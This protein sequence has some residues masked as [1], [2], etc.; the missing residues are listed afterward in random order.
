M[1]NEAQGGWTAN[2]TAYKEIRYL[3]L[4][5]ITSFWTRLNSIPV[6]RNRFGPKD[7]N[8]TGNPVNVTDTCVQNYQHYDIPYLHKITTFAYYLELLLV[9]NQMTTENM[10]RVGHVACMEEKRNTYR[11]LVGKSEVKGPLAGLRHRW[12]DNIKVAL[13]EI[14]WKD[15]DWI[16]LSQDTIP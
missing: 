10:I 7:C 3:M 5:S 4:K 2:R 12:E 8:L 11:I 14:G 15:M 9:P 1:P 6:R 13:K 16:H